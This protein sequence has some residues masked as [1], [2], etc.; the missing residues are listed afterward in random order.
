MTITK[1]IIKQEL[2]NI[3]NFFLMQDSIVN[4]T[5]KPCD[6]LV[7][8]IEK[9]VKLIEDAPPELQGFFN[10]KYRFGSTIQQMAAKWKVSVATVNRLQ[11]KLYEYLFE[12]LNKEEK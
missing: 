6:K 3:K 9:Y 12:N 2:E 10:E 11:S 7:F 4:G 1:K 8:L 5:L